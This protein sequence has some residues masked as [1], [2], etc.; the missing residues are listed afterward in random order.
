LENHKNVYSELNNNI[1]WT[2]WLGNKWL[3]TFTKVGK[4]FTTQ[5][6]K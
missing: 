4:C 1:V 2:E 3:Q 5:F 6:L